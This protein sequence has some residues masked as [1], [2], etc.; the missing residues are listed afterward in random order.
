M[1]LWPL[2]D[3]KPHTCTVLPISSHTDRPHLY[4]P[5]LLMYRQIQN[6]RPVPTMTSW[7]PTH[8]ETCPTCTLDPDWTQRLIL[9]PT[10]SPHTQRLRAPHLHP[11]CLLRHQQNQSFVTMLTLPPQTQKS[12]ASYPRR[13]C[14][15]EHGK[16]LVW[17]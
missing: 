12:R 15:F 8:P 3:P 14:F 4:L 9:T 5:C 17:H 10:M 1:S 13:L 11:L 16:T 2:I 7:S 6:L